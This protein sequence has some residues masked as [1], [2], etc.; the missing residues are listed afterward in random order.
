MPR[1]NMIVD[2]G[3]TPPAL[4]EFTRK[5]REFEA[6]LVRIAENHDCK[7]LAFWWNEYSWDAYATVE[8]DDEQ[9]EA[10]F[11][12]VEAYGVTPIVDTDEKSKHPGAKSSGT[13]YPD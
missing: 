4:E 8:G 7:V 12:E 3:G 13:N 6:N 10:F 11:R 5:P 9:A 2:G 1:W